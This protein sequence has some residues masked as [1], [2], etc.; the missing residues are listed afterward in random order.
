MLDEGSGAR[1]R[2]EYGHSA[3]L[4]AQ[5]LAGVYGRLQFDLGARATV[6]AA[7]HGKHLVREG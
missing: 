4:D 6:A 3:L 2:A 1:I 7:S 5:L